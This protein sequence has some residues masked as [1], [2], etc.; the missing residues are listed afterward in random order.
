MDKAS[1][2][3]SL[4]E[5][6]L[7]KASLSKRKINGGDGVFGFGEFCDFDVRVRF[8]FDERTK[9]QLIIKKIVVFW[10]C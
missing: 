5:E 10:W 4:K 1:N 2:F 8:R 3:L 6:F 7:G 9:E